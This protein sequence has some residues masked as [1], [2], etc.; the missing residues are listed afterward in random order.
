[1]GFGPE[2]YNTPA[3]GPEKDR[4]LFVYNGGFLTQGR[5]R[6]ILQLAGYSI[7]IGLPSEDGD[8]VAVWGNSPTAH[9]GEGVAQ[10]RDAP[11]V[12]VEDALLRSLFPG[13]SGEPPLGLV[14]DHKGVHFDPSQPSDLET[15]LATHPLDDTALLNRA[16]ICIERLKE[17]HLSKYAAIPLDTP[18]P[19]AGYVVVIDQTE[20]D[21]S[22]TASGADRSR[23]LEM[24][25]YAQEEHPGARILIKTH[26]ETEA[27]HRKGYFRDEDLNER[28][29]FLTDPISPYMLFEGAIGVYTVS[30]GLGF[31]AIFA[32]HKPRV[33]GQPFY[34]GWGLTSDAFEV[35]RRQRSLTRAQLFAAAMILYPKWYDPYR[36]TLCTLETV[37]D[38]LEAQARSWRED[39][40]GWAAAGMSLWKRPHLQKFYGSFE[41]VMFN[42]APLDISDRPQMIWAGKTDI[43]TPNLTRVEDGFLRSRGLGAE[44][45]PPLSLAADDLGIYY[46]PSRPSRLEKWIEA[47]ATLRLDQE[48]RAGRLIRALTDAG[49]SKY[50]T[51]T[52][53][54]SLPEGHRIL[55]C[56]QVG[57]DASI[58]TGTSDIS[59]NQALLDAVRAA[60]P[61][62][63]IL[64]KP[65]PDVEAGLRD[66]ALTNP[67]IADH[68]VTKTDPAALLAQV[69]EVHTMT[70]L[71]GFEALIRGLPVTTY[72]A[73][74]YAGWGLTTDRSDVPPRRRAT[75]TLEGLVHAALID[76]P[77]YLDPKTGLPCPVEVALE[78]LS[79]GDIPAPGTA[80]RLLSKLQGLLASKAHLW[81]R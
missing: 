81:R 55:V 77:R 49:L 56:G 58:R 44:L 41:P 79:Q 52:A 21:A 22:V 13:R 11:V 18:P 64:F 51:G 20:G 68:I 48:L 36:D 3:A 80:N 63:M 4:R 67:D 39:R 73:P 10:K 9:R 33:F 53:P 54:A 12:R 14:V 32:G 26:P 15:L 5:I 38:T 6:R 50:N 16:R 24:L 69:N 8:A 29:E 1:M 17:A 40:H 76:Y 2:I 31:E 19:A 74:F 70:S 61:D 65:H 30:S 71:M 7:H 37:I 59:S 72:G 62:A 57:D 75:P 60:N 35:Q 47:R 66:G 43:D 78:R 27:G 25:Y 34:A 46:D 45:V 42:D 23:F 28:I